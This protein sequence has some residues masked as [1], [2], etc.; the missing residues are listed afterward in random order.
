MEFYMYSMITVNI[1][2]IAQIR[3]KPETKYT[4][5]ASLIFPNFPYC[6]YVQIMEISCQLP[7]VSFNFQKTT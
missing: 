1:H 3:N 2:T 4:K 7:K 6:N 5:L